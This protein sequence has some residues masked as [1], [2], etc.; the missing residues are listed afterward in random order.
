M[1]YV[2]R[3]NTEGFY[4]GSGGSQAEKGQP[5]QS[6]NRRGQPD[7]SPNLRYRVIYKNTR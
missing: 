4:V 1:V 7:D 6:K 3:E 2:V 5:L